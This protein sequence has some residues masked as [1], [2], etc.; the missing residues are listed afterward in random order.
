MGEACL[1]YAWPELVV[2]PI[3]G[4][5]REVV[6][7]G[8]ASLRYGLLGTDVRGLSLL[9]VKLEFRVVRIVVRFE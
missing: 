7:G 3:Q 4:F 6:G 1:S 5:T 9:S 8:G 2:L